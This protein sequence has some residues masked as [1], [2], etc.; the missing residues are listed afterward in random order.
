MANYLTAV[1]WN[2]ARKR[3]IHS[4]RD[5]LRSVC[6]LHTPIHGVASIRETLEKPND[7][8]A[9]DLCQTCASRRSD[10]RSI[11]NQQCAGSRDS[12]HV[13]PEHACFQSSDKDA[14]G[15]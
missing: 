2:D 6:Y 3:V 8:T 1:N 11:A 14:A 7:I 12:D 10:P 13:L 15:I 9:V 4:Y 5:W